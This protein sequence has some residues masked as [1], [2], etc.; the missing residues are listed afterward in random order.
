MRMPVVAATALVGSLWAAKPAGAADCASL[1]SLAVPSTTITST[2]LVPA[3]AGFPEYCNVNGYVDTE[4]V[5]ALRLP[6]QWNGKFYF[7]SSGGLDGLV[8]AP[9]PGLRLGYAEIATNT[10]HA[11]TN[12][13]L[14]DGSW[15]FHH[16]ER[17]INW[18][19]RSSHVVAIAGKTITSAYYGSAP[20]YSY[21]VGCSG[22]GRHAA[23]SAQRYPTD[24]DGVVS[25][26]PFLSP[27]GQVI[28]WNWNDQ[29]LARTPIPP[30]KLTRIAQAVLDECDAKDGVVDGL[31]SD[32]RRCRFDPKAIACPAGIDRSDCLT[33]GEVASL[34]KFYGGPRDSH[35]EQ[36]FPGW[37]PGVENLG[38]PRA[39]VNTV[40]G[41]P[42]EL[43][44]LIPDN[45][46]KYFVFGPGFDPLSF[47][48]DRDPSKLEPASE[49]LDVKPDFS[50]F[51]EAGGKIIMYHGWAD[52]RLVPVL[53]IQFHGAVERNLREED[54]GNIDDFYRLFMVPGMLHC[55]GGT[56]PT[57]FDAFGALVKWV[58]QGIAP[59][60]I[61]GSHFTKGVV[62]RTRP[63][64]PYPQEAVYA[65]HGSV[66]DAANFVCQVRHVRDTVN[67]D[68][69][70]KRRENDGEAH[71]DNDR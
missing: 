15:A 14:Y 8:A 39:L 33:E 21:F 38:W 36:L 50:S 11:S 27:P 22:G 57:S 35:G 12:G 30:A 34:V 46:L 7:T 6:T 31:I 23:M 2:A 5:F 26:D 69:Y 17:Q 40:N 47:N 28:A 20:R 29:V 1:T 67:E 65:G 68:Y 56:G 13:T 24:F 41:G 62:D 70:S 71:E 52:P 37:E 49:L 63:L 48:F 64:C 25:G 19:Y 54:D 44:V 60:R 32:P 42:G 58:E 4:I 53:S 45:F 3:G 51:A 66:D 18:A 9:G 59:D 55:A 10:G 61:I 16:T 43:L